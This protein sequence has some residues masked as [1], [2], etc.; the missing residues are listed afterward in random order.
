MGAS[1]M[2]YTVASCMFEF[3][4]SLCLFISLLFLLVLL[5]LLLLY[6]LLLLLLLLLLLFCY[7][8]FLFSAWIVHSQSI[9]FSQMEWVWQTAISHNQ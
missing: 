9:C 3:V 7:V 6:F 4:L 5:L 2:G 1:Q 8:L